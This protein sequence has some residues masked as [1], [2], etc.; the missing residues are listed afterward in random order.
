MER[1][2][3]FYSRP[4]LVRPTA[5]YATGPAARE[6][7]NPLLRQVSIH[8]HH[9]LP[10]YQH[11]HTSLETMSLMRGCI[12]ALNSSTTTMACKR[13]CVPQTFHARRR[14]AFYIDNAS[15]YTYYRHTKTNTRL[16][17]KPECHVDR[18]LQQSPESGDTMK[19]KRKAIITRAVARAIHTPPL[20]GCASVQAG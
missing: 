16:R 12:A 11:P 13:S 5:R 19:P 8:D 14:R 3:S 7:R 10:R 1:C 18:P 15:I 17:E 6:Y 2:R 20:L 9:Y 4:S